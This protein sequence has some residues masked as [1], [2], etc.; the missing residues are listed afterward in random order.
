MNPVELFIME[1]PAK[2]HPIYK[3]LREI[4]L[5]EIPQIQEKLAYGIPFFYLKKRILY[6]APKKNGIDLGFCDGFLL[7]NHPILEIKDR[8]Q[9]R[10]IFFDRLENIKEEILIPLIHEAVLVQKESKGELPNLF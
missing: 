4:I 7:S 8:S 10:T 3:K 5:N 6:F 1:Q 2:F 9:V